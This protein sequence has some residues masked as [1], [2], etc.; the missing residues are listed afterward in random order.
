MRASPHARQGLVVAGPAEEEAGAFDQVAGALRRILRLEP[1]G[2]LEVV[3]RGG[4]LLRRRVAAIG[5]QQR[6]GAQQRDPGRGILGPLDG[7]T[8]RRRRLVETPSRCS[9][10]AQRRV[11]LVQ[12]GPKRDGR[13]EVGERL[14]EPAGL[15]VHPAPIHQEDVA[16]VVGGSRSRA[17]R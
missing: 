12:P 5:M 7:P 16:E 15:E 10:L 2:L 3:Q 13:L 1:E 11:G 8:K 17:S 4:A 14:R 6:P 9:E